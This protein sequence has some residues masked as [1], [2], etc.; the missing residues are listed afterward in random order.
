MLHRPIEGKPKTC[1]II[2]DVDQWCA[3]IQSETGG[4]SAGKG[5]SPDSPA[6]GVDLVILNLATLSNGIIL[7]S[8]KYSLV[9]V[10][11][12]QRQLSRR[13][14]GSHNRERARIMLAKAWR[15]IKNQ[16][17]DVIHKLSTSLVR[18]YSTIVFEDL[19]IPRMMKNHHLASAITDTSWGKLRQLTAY[20][21]EKRGSRVI[22]VDPWGTSQKC[23][24]CGEMVRKELSVRVH[25]CPKCG[26]VLD[27]DV[28][29]ARNILAAGLEQARVEERPLLVQR[30]R[31]SKFVRMQREI[32]DVKPKGSSHESFTSG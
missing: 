3:C 15:W 19:R 25:D 9:R 7:K 16:R 8:P 1:T 11:S 26:L 6:V 23:S 24:G 27:R 4:Q 22:L 30:R 5:P 13:K 10:R 18:G 31:A 12:L 20:K 2:K 17:Q 28:N 29:A 32:R 21:A 14:K